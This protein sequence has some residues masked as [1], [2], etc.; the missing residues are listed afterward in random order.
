MENLPL[1]LREQHSDVDEPHVV[2]IVTAP[3]DRPPRLIGPEKEESA[4]S[5][6]ESVITDELRDIV[7]SRAQ[8]AASKDEIVNAIFD[9]FSDTNVDPRRVSLE[10]FKCIVVEAV[11]TARYSHASSSDLLAV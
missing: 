11:R 2:A 5:K 7:R 4:M 1:A 6:H 3:T 10:D 8:S 9:A